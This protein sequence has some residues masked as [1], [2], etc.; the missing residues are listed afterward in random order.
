MAAFEGSLRIRGGIEEA[1]VHNIPTKTSYCGPADVQSY[2]RVSSD[3]SCLGNATPSD[4]V[5]NLAYSDT[6]SPAHSANNI[7]PHFNE[8][9][10]RH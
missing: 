5:D 8:V 1:A 6:H 9:F 10:G 7:A 4:K 2:F 3:P